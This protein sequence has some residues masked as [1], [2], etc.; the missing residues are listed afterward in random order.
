MVVIVTVHTGYGTLYVTIQE[1]L[2]SILTSYIL[3]SYP[4]YS[5]KLSKED[6]DK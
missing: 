3:S 5:M 4:P 1:F 2:C 6:S